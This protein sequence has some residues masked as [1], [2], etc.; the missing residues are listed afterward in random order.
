MQ[1]SL[2]PGL[3]PYP[4][5]LSRVSLTYGAAL[6]G[7]AFQFRRLVTLTI[8]PVP[9]AIMLGE[10]KGGGKQRGRGPFSLVFLRLI[11]RSN[12]RQDEP[13]CSSAFSSPDVDTDRLMTQ[14]TAPLLMPVG[15]WSAC[16]IKRST[17]T[18]TPEKAGDP[19]GPCCTLPGASSDDREGHRLPAECALRLRPPQGIQPNID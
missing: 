3:R 14:T 12:G 1:F 2:E 16:S 11:R 5:A 6:K 15:L 4:Y 9:S 8:A 13:T 19:N 18:P 17:A 10:N 7:Q